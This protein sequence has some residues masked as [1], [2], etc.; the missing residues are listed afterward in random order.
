MGQV[1]HKQAI[2][3]RLPQPGT[4]GCQ[5]F[6]TA[7]T[8]DATSV[9]DGQRLRQIVTVLALATT[10][11]VVGGSLTALLG[12][13][14]PVRSTGFWLAGLAAL[15]C[16]GNG[17][18]GIGFGRGGDPRMQQMRRVLA[19]DRGLGEMTS[20]GM[21]LFVGLPLFLLAMVLLSV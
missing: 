17:A 19:P 7:Q 18:S 15:A 8:S 6:S 11:A 1:S 4:Q 13:A 16:F 21:A 5:A 9:R 10:L 12:G 20:L 2:L 14:S 3:T